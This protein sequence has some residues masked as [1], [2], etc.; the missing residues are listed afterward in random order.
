MGQAMDELRRTYMTQRLKRLKS[1]LRSFLAS[2]ALLAIILHMILSVFSLLFL[3]LLSL[4]PE[5][6]AK[7]LTQLSKRGIEGRFLF[8]LRIRCLR[9][10]ASIYK[11]QATL[12]SG[13]L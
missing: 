9:A 4:A 13:I 1:W 10:T 7:S 6:L 3:Q 5:L 11:A 12:L 2:L 8:Y